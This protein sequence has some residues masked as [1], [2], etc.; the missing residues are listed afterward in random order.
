MIIAAFPPSERG[1]RDRLLDGVVGHRDRDR[2]AGRRL[3]RRR[4]VVAL[5]LRHQR[6]VRAASRSA[7]V[8]IAVPS[9]AARAPRT[10]S[11]T[12]SAR[13]LTA[14]GLAGPVLALI[15]QPVRRLG[16]P[17]G[18]GRRPGRHRA[19]RAL[20]ACTSARTP[21][22]MLPLELFKR[23]NF[24]VGNLQTFAMYGGLGAMF[25]FLT[26]FLQ[27]VAGYDALRGRA[28]DAPDDARHVHAL[29]AG[30]AARRPLRAAAA[31]WASGRWSRAAGI[32]A[33]AAAR[34]RHRL[35]DR[36]VP[37]AAVFSLGLVGDGRAAD[38]DGAGR[39]RR[40]QRR[41]SPR[42]ST[43]RSRA[44][45]GCCAS[46]RSARSSPRSSPRRSTSGSPGG[47]AAGRPDREARA[48]R[49]SRA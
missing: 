33:D 19:A 9:R 37:G 17:A 41:A 42:A 44:S 27:Q 38:R 22:P 35:L 1:A 11:S 13:L 18:L 29:Q 6:P 23:R 40:A 7:L 46:P 21:Q 25:F 24:A 20:R 16:Q 48:A 14:L 36:A 30:R 12:G 5:D 8:A 43:T 28:R 3:A 26:L 10:C 34:R 45:P 15:R 2:A 39:R 47:A 4:R 31:S 32:V 49:R